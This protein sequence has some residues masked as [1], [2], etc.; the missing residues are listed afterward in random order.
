MLCLESAP[1]RHT[2]PRP[3]DLKSALVCV[4]KEE[5]GSDAVIAKALGAGT[6]CAGDAFF[7]QCCFY[8]KK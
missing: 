5:A 8:W 2:A 7:R 3:A 4:T 6:A 1:G